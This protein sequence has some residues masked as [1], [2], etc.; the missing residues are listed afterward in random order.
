MQE[1]RIKPVWW[2]TRFPMV[3]EGRVGEELVLVLD[4]VLDGFQLVQFERPLSLFQL[5]K[6]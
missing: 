3:L 6:K 5:V 2:E 4:L 1:L